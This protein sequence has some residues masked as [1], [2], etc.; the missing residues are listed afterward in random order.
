MESVKTVNLK[1]REFKE[2]REWL[3]LNSLNSL[4]SLIYLLNQRD[5]FLV[6]REP[7]A[8]L[9]KNPDDGLHFGVLLIVGTLFA[10]GGR[11]ALTTRRDLLSEVVRC[12]ASEK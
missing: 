9:G 1:F 12:G 7:S 4:N 2:L 6:R 8:T 10:S 5:R 11:C 3:S